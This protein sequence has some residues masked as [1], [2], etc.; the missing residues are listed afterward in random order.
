MQKA[1]KDG[2]HYGVIP[3]TNKPS[4]LKPGAEKINFLFRIGTGDLEVTRTDLPEGHREITI[5][6]PMI[7]IPTGTAL[8]WGIGSCSTME[9]K[10]RY[11]KAA[12]KCPKCGKETII[13]GKDEYGGGWLCWTK[14]EGCGAKY[15]DDAPEITAQEVGQIE[16]KDIADV[17]N[18]VLKMA[19]KRSYVDGTIK[20]SAASDFFTQDV[21]EEDVPKGNGAT[22]HEPSGY[23]PSIPPR[24][25]VETTITG[26]PAASLGN[27]LTAL[28]ANTYLTEEDRVKIRGEY[29]ATCTTDKRRGE[30]LDKWEATIVER[31]AADMSGAEKAFFED[32]NKPLPGEKVYEVG[33]E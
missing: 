28:I 16:N 22:S 18:T 13:K 23:T 31:K 33:A 15:P 25:P 9:S 29:R 19:A 4:L 14:K 11:R 8:A 24:A 6:T 10:Y 21:E 17:Y 2:Q 1:L 12:R 32:Q 3:G 30:Y 5:K 20:A 26:K 27:R 7:H